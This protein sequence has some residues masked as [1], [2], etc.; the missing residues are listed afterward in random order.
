MEQ[1]KRFSNFFHGWRT[2]QASY[3]RKD[4]PAP[5]APRDEEAAAVCLQELRRPEACASGLSA[6]RQKVSGERSSGGGR[7]GFGF[8]CVLS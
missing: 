5:I 8:M 2:Y 7:S 1:I 6:V 3:E 4:R